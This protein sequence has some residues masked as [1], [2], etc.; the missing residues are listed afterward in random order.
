MVRTCNHPDDK[1]WSMKVTD[2]VHRKLNML[3]NCSMSK[4]DVIES[5][6]AFYEKHDS[7]INKISKRKDLLKEIAV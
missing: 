6:I 3:G 7:N 1:I 4:S 5:L 2:T